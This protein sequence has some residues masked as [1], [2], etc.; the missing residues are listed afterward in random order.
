[1]PSETQTETHSKTRTPR[2]AK[3]QSARGAR[4]RIVRMNTRTVITHGLRNGGGLDFYHRAV[5]ASWPAFFGALALFFLLLNAVFAALYMC[6]HASI[7][8]LSPPGFGG[9][10]FFSVETLATV[11]Y[12]DMHPQTVYAHEIAALEIFTGMSSIALAT[13]L[14]FVRFSRPRARIIFARYAVVHTFDGRPT[15]IVRAANGRQNVIVEARAKLRVMREE[16]TPEGYML[17]RIHDLKLVR[18]Q[19][20]IFLFGWNLMHVIDE[21]S[22]LYGESAQSLAACNA[23]LMVMIEGS[24]ESTTQMMQSRYTWLA[25][26]IRWQHRF[27]DL[28]YDDEE[29]VTH[30]DYTKF[31]QIVPI[32]DEARPPASSSSSSSSLGL[33]G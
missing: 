17:R 24:D 11:G 33:S 20:P 8:N 27:V 18:D 12:G 3:R 25:D 31:D 15:L 13:G 14:I 23:A 29:G 30:L 2:T 9:A 16:T 7:A 26:K 22:P 19:H 6:G 4:G 21:E 5:T 32:D 1:M 10:F 28:L